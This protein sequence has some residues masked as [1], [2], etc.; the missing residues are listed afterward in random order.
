MGS[1]ESCIFAVLVA[2]DAL[3][4]VSGLQ[5][6]ISA[7]NRQHLLCLPKIVPKA[8]SARRPKMETLP[9][10]PAFE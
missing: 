1:C 4:D 5:I 2:L 9:K 8:Q 7:E 10:R 6:F 3:P